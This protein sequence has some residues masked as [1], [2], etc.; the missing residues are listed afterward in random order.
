MIIAA[1]GHRSNKLGGSGTYAKLVDFAQNYMRKA[2]PVSV[3]SGMALGWDTAWAEAAYR[4][5][6][7]FV[8]AVPFAGQEA[9]WPETSKLKYRL[10]LRRAARV[11]VICTGSYARAKFQRRN[12]WMVD[13][14][15]GV[16]ALWDGSTGGTANCVQYARRVGKPIANLWSEWAAIQ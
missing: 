7:P 16:V 2:M 4:Q 14:A 11:H 15:D 12:E 13:N 9:M 10:L 3:I 8:A 6:I 5:S 1:T